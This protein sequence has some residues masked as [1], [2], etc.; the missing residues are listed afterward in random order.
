MFTEDYYA[1]MKRMEA[2]PIRLPDIRPLI[3]L[4]LKAGAQRTPAS[5]P[6]KDP[7]VLPFWISD[8]PE[9]KPAPLDIQFGFLELLNE[10]PRGKAALAYDQ[11]FERNPIHNC[12]RCMIRAAFSQKKKR[13]RVTVHSKW[14]PD[15]LLMI[16]SPH[17]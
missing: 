3:V 1:G 2:A 11:N 4:I 10:D 5:L 17:P 7:G 6:V 9:G 14:L 16:R 13:E 12:Y 15:D 8:S